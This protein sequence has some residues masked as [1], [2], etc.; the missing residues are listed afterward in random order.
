M[1]DEFR[2]GDPGRPDQPREVTVYAT[3]GVRLGMLAG[4]LGVIGLTWGWPTVVF[5]LALVVMIFLHELG[6]FMTARWTGMK[7]TEFFIGFGPKIW[8]FTR[9]E[10]EYGL[11]VLPVGAYVRIIG[12]NNLEE[13]DPEDEPRAYRNKSFPRKLLV[14]SAGS[15]MH[16]G[17][18]FLVAVVLLVGVGRPGGTLVS[19]ER[20][21]E[22]WV[23][24]DVTPDSAADEAGLLPED[25]V[26]GWNGEPI[27]TFGDIQDAVAA[28]EVGEAVTLTVKRD[29]ETFSVAADLGDKSSVSS[30]TS[31]ADEPFLGI[32]PAPGADERV[33]LPAGVYRATVETGEAML[34]MVEGIGQI[35]SPSGLGNFAQLVS[36]GGSNSQVEDEPGAATSG[37]SSEAQADNGQRPMSILGVVK[38]GGEMGEQGVAPMLFLF[39]IVNVFIGLFN[40]IPLLPFDGGHAAVA[41]YER[42]RSRR[43]EVYRAD[44]AKL[45]PLTYAVVM[46]LVLLFSGALYLDIV[47]PVEL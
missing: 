19:E 15:M 25:R 22:S 8:S 16:F 39:F 2:S 46:A 37:G 35:F 42:A 6:H 31:A 30:E 40:L 5:I 28:S 36:E 41:I 20:L 14:V 27:S 38:I 4:L 10:T 33:G 21:E 29:G 44:Y 45:M 43:G 32:G 11:K 13:V 23:I 34:V 26:V 7:A 24:S 1:V 18:A 17:L 12:M 9:G 47:N 3:S